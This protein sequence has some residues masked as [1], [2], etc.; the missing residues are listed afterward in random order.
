LTSELK[1][2]VRRLKP[3]KQLTQ[4][5]ERR[6]RDDLTSASELKVS[7]SNKLLLDTNVLIRHAAGELPEHVLRV[8]EQATLFQSTVCISEICVGLANRN[9][10]HKNW[11][12]E[13]EYWH[14]AFSAVPDIRI[15]SP[16]ES[17]SLDAGLIAGTLTRIQNYQSSQS[18]DALNDALIFLTAAKHGIPVLTENRKD[19]D[20]IQQLAGRGAFYWFSKK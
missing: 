5:A 20:L 2:A 3:Q 11:P 16:D 7:R 12:K 1:A 9:V 4:I 14:E 8:I 19:F 17:I 15:L 10:S 6:H 18:K 13:I